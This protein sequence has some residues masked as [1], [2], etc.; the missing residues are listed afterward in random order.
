MP[1]ADQDQVKSILA[2]FESR[3]RSIVD[4]AW[5]EWLGLPNRGR[6]LFPKRVRA[7]F[8]FDAIARLAL[9]EFED[10]PNIHVILK[11]QTVQFLFRDQVLVRFKKANDKGVG[12]NIETQAV[13]DFIDPQRNIPDLLTSHPPAVRGLAG[14]QILWACP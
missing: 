8:V 2:T 7:T 10:D 11:K 4:Q 13:L 5:Q 14:S 9:A 12:S 1:I 6:F 3:I